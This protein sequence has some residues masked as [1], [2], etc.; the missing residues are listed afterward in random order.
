MSR[1]LRYRE[2]QSD[3]YS[4]HRL[5]VYMRVSLI[6][7]LPYVF[8]LRDGMLPSLSIIQWYTALYE[9]ESLTFVV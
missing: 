6:G 9:V 5:A 2:T 4:P 3:V 1:Y 8:V 7:D